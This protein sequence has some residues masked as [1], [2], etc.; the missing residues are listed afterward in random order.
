MHTHTLRNTHPR[1]R[2]ANPCITNYKQQLR[3]GRSRTAIFQPGIIFC[4]DY[5]EIYT[6]RK[7]T[8]GINLFTHHMR[9]DGAVQVYKVINHEEEYSNGGL[10]NYRANINRYTVQIMHNV[11]FARARG[12]A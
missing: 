1:E 12:F 4:E 3:I 8:M 9:K 10:N 6:V 11:A 2:R 5:T 7:Q